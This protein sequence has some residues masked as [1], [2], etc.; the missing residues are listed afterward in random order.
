MRRVTSCSRTDSTK[1]ELRSILLLAPTA[2]AVVVSM[3][4]YIRSW[5]AQRLLHTV[6]EVCY[7][8]L[9]C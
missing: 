2:L 6:Y 5:I 7:L 1:L 4:E 3:C 8:R 9:P